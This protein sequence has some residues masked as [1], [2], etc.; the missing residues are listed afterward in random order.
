[1]RSAW[2]LIASALV[3]G[4][5]PGRAAAGH[6]FITGHDPDYHAYHGPN[7]LGER[8]LGRTAIEFARN[9]STKPFLYVESLLEPTPNFAPR[10]SRTAPYLISAFG[11]SASDFEVADGARLASFADFRAA[12]DNYSAIVVASDHGGML[13]AAELGFLNAHRADIAD[14]VNAGGGLAAFAESNYQY[15]IG[16]ETPYGFVPGP[17]V[18]TTFHTSFTNNTVTAMGASLGL[19]DTDVSG[20]YT[21]AF[22][23]VTGGLSPVDLL[24]GDPSRPLSLASASQ[25]GGPAGAPE[26]SSLVLL[27][28]ASAGLV[29]YRLR[30][31]AG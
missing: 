25:G 28:F 5:A 15:L 1:M 14:Y 29:G 10:N 23:S 16:N 24:S 17:V 4:L 9:G 12:L 22:F 2:F 26:P 31:S 30:R 27:G 6:I 20:T 7:S 8:N 19:T 13:T 18:S 11:Y 3:A 21:H